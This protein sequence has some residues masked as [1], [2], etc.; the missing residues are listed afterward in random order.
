MDERLDALPPL[1]PRAAR[2]HVGHGGTRLHGLRVGEEGAE[3]LGPDAAADLVEHGGLLA[4]HP[5]VEPLVGLVA[6]GAIQL[7]QQEQPAADGV[8][9]GFRE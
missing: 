7:A 3:V 4:L 9:P 2:E 5:R 1:F 8:G 6:G